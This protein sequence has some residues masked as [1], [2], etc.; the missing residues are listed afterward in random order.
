VTVFAVRLPRVPAVR[1]RVRVCVG[2]CMKL[3]IGV[4]LSASLLPGV[5]AA[6]QTASAEAASGARA[7]RWPTLAQVLAARPV[8]GDDPV[9][10]R[11][12]LAVLDLP[13]TAQTLGERL[14]TLIP[15]RNSAV[16][17]ELHGAGL[18]RELLFV[19]PVLYGVRYQA[20]SHRLSVDADLS[21]DDT[22]NAVLLD[23]TIVGPSGRDLVVAAEA[24]A[25]GYIQHVD[26][27]A[28][29]RGDS[30][31]T[32]VRGDLTVSPGVFAQTDGHF[33]IALLCRLAPPYLVDRRDHT[34]PTD[35]NPTDITT[36]TSTLFADVRAA[37]L[38]SPPS[39][40]VLAKNLRL[41]N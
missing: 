3:C 28:L 4:C 31:K 17:R 8:V 25:K 24:K 11:D 40:T 29:R 16:Q 12:A 27:V 36:R 13:N 35:E 32:E 20:S 18:D 15:D 33:A 6:A 21:S 22:P 41:S 2:V 38:I 10:V 23:K 37:W 9:A 7:A 5:A 30:H 1:F 19:V 26:I 14:R 39:G 34:D